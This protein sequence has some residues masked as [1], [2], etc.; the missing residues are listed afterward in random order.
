MFG[1]ADDNIRLDTHSLKFFY[2]CLCRFCLKL[3][4]SLNIRDQC[5][6]DQDRVFV[7]DFMLELTDRL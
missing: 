5:D 1:T 7:S 6:M 2:T 3:T 4:G